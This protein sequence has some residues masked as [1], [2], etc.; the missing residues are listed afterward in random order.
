MPVHRIVVASR[1]ASR[2]EEA[3][4][5][6]AEVEDQGP[7]LL[8]SAAL[9]AAD[10]F[11]RELA[12]ERGSLFG[13]RRATLDSLAYRLA[14][15]ALARDGMT[16]AS[17]L[18]QEAVVARLLDVTAR[19]RR[20]GPLATVA[21]G[22]GLIRALTSTLHECRLH[23]IRPDD[24]AAL[25]DVGETLALL[26]V[27][28]E[29]LSRDH[30][31]ADRALTLSLARESASSIEGPV[32][33]LDVPVESPLEESLIEAI[34]RS[35]S[36][37]PVFATAAEA[38]LASVA[39]LS[40]ALGCEPRP[41][42][43]SE[44]LGSALFDLQSH[45]FGETAPPRRDRPED[46]AVI[47]APG[48]AQEAS[49]LARAMQREAEQGL[50]FD[51]MAVL[52]RSPEVYTPLLEDT[53]ARAGI[54]AYFENGTKRPD[55][56]GRAFLA[57]IDCS[58]EE[59]SAV[60][61]AEYLSLSQIPKLDALGAPIVAP[62]P[63]EED[64][65]WA[66]PRHA[67]APE[68]SPE[69]V[70]LDLFAEPPPK[71]E[72]PESEPVLAGTLRAPWRWEKLLVDAAVIGGRD[73]WERRLSGLGRELDMQLLEIED[74]EGVE[75]ER[76]RRERNDL[77][78]LRNFALPLIEILDASPASASWGVWIEWLEKLASASL[79]SPEGVLS[80][81]KE[82]R[83]MASVGPVSILEVREVL[84]ERLTLL[85]QRPSGDRYGK[86]WVAPIEAVR[87]LSF[88]MVL[89]PGLAERMFPRKILEDPLLLDAARL[90]LGA[91]LPLQKDR[92][93]KERL[94]LRLAIGAASRRIVFSYPSIDLAKGRAK[95]P[96]F[97]LL[98]VARAS[99]GEL[100]DFET[101]ARDAASSSGARLGW[102]APRDR[103]QAID[104]AEFDLAFLADSLRRDL[105]DRE[106][107]GS[108]RYL[109]EV[110]PA[111][112]R[113]LRA[114]FQRARPKHF[115]T[116]DGFLEASEAARAVLAQHRLEARAYSVTALE[117]YSACPYRFYLNAI[118][119]LRPRETVEA[120]THLDPLTKGSI[121][122]VAQFEVSKRLGEA[123]LLPVRPEN[124]DEVLQ[125][126]EVVFDEVEERFEEDLAPAI[127]RIWKDE[128]ERIRFDLR[129]WLR[130]EAS[131]DDGFVPYRRE[132]TFGMRP[133]GP[134][135]PAS[136]L[137]VAVLKN[138]L[139]LRGAIDLVEKRDSDGKVRVTDHKSGKVWM[140]EGAVVNGGENLQP[141][142][143]TLAYEA[144]TGEKVESSRLY[145]VTQRAG[146]AERVV[147]ADEEALKVVAEFQRRLDEIIEEGFFPASPK[148]KPGCAYCDYLAVC[149]PR[150]Q[151][152]ARRKQEDPRLSPLNWLRSLT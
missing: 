8:I 149:G 83:P 63:E 120:V 84:S 33:L 13:F 23:R 104:A 127:E 22:P 133:T 50:P 55:P 69:P 68:P 142:L 16:T 136:T 111:L 74:Q 82:L 81:L 101:L 53:F 34:A 95:V 61:F 76:L 107:Q 103:A 72:A 105:T 49:E 118:L 138:G 20:L 32:L 98:E 121:L 12:S 143:Y 15:P 62:A 17:R 30:G 93:A 4:R 125:L 86:V 26:L 43:A 114:K 29:D 131:R 88:D 7:V 106:V 58:A 91:E 1:A 71:V 6:L 47:S 24:L 92:I 90:R 132:F 130:R 39:R 70:Q 134:A 18:A 145:F 122:H 102:P 89:V 5:W 113:S 112:A 54:P 128:L 52:L 150:M 57:L 42:T 21:S 79:S 14:L 40:R 110:N 64:V 36:A 2:R 48:E 100:P 78:H 37:V 60:R 152:D 109:V 137:E 151:L 10:H 141:I 126:F 38:D 3:R 75:A 67:L 9:E 94:L 96:S 116:A 124:L 146:Y 51:R 147:R 140:P 27:R 77:L 25:G 11:L 139:R 97:Y 144:L 115:T 46:V 66:P 31:V 45:V 108:G 44:D 56:A 19:E 35:Q 99:Q 148:E 87:G 123:N 135:D 80:L 59:L 117:K 65:L 28:Y 119:R 73:R 129:G 41:P 85:P